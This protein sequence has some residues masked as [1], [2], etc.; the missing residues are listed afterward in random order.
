MTQFFDA[1]WILMMNIPCL[2]FIVN[3]TNNALIIIIDIRIY[4]VGGGKTRVLKMLV[5][6]VR[7]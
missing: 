6:F 4:V 3:I 2:V 1:G 7:K 5:A